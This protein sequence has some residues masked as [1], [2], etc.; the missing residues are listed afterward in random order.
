MAVVGCC[1]G[2]HGEEVTALRTAT[3]PEFVSFGLDA[4]RTGKVPAQGMSGL[5][6]RDSAWSERR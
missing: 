4:G 6:Q 1:P 5:Q 3:L 2:G